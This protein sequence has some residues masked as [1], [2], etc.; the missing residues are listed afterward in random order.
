VI[1]WGAHVPLFYLPTLPVVV[2]SP[3]RELSLAEHVRAGQALAR[4]PGRQGLVAS[5]DHAH[6]HAAGGPYHV[7]PEA[8]RAYD[9]AVV[10]LVEENRLEGLLE[11][12][13][14]AEAGLADSLWQL[15]VL[16]GALGDGFESDLLAYEAPSY[17]GMLVASFEPVAPARSAIPPQRTTSSESASGRDVASARNPIVGGPTRKPM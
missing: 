1:V 17:F 2:I 6:T 10:A 9:H 7:D 11:L 4:A 14:A 15:L 13:P 12:G 3:A 5:A 8:A 16:R